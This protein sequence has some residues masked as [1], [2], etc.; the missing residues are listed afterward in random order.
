MATWSARALL[1]TGLQQARGGFARRLPDADSDSHCKRVARADDAVVV[2]AQAVAHA[3][4][5]R[6]HGR[7]RQ[8]I[9][10]DQ[11]ERRYAGFV[12]A[13]AA[14]RADEPTRPELPQVV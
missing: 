14:V 6:V 5:S 11:L 8:T 3:R 10:F 2:G 13:L 7:A 4:G 9:R 1:T 12:L